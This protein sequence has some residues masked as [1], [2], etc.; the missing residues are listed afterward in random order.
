MHSPFDK[1]THYQQGILTITPD[2]KP[3]RNPSLFPQ[4][5]TKAGATLHLLGWWIETRDDHT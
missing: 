1:K 3:S 5:V 2:G 4:E